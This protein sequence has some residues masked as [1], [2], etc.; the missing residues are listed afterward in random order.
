MTEPDATNGEVPGMAACGQS[1]DDAGPGSGSSIDNRQL[2]EFL[3][4]N[5]RTT[6]LFLALPV[7]AEQFLNFLV[8]FVDTLLSGR[9][10]MAATS[11]IGTAAYVNWLV[12]LIFSLVATGTTALVAR[13]W[14]AGQRDAAS[15]VASSSISLA[16]GMGIVAAALL[17]MTAPVFGAFLELEA[18][19]SVLLVRYLRLSCFGYGF[20]SVLLIG[21]A[22]LR[23]S[24][25]M[26]APMW[27]LGLVS[28]LNVVFSWTLVFGVGLLP[29]IGIDGIAIGTVAARFVGL[30]LMLWILVGGT[31]GLVGRPSW[32]ST[33]DFATISRV[34]RIG[35]PAATDS[36]LMWAGHFLFLR[37]VAGLGA[38]SQGKAILAAHI[39]GMQVEAIN[40]LPAWAW[41]TAAATM[42][43]Q[44]LG[45]GR[46]DRVR[47]AGH[48][49]MLQS[50]V[51]AVVVM[52]LFLC[53]A[54]F[55]YE[56][57]HKNQEVA[58]VGVPAIRLLAF[59]EVPLSI[60]IVY[61]VGIR[62]AGETF[63]PMI[64][65]GV[66]IFFVRL[67]IGYWLG[68]EM[69]LGLIGAWGGM[70]ADVV[71][72]ATAIALYFRFGKWDQ[73]GI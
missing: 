52:I 72:R 44:C 51:V 24:G 58:S 69:D 12:E 29:A 3:T 21:S 11:A 17:Y 8:G 37:V 38:G 60:S 53:G 71:V 57:M 35:I 66:G 30:V 48:E 49:A 33:M 22:A 47:P 56:L 43:G 23:G 50:C 16:L 28:V 36:L 42:I 26:R 59:F 34:L 70:G 55:I 62:G 65:N 14:G 5:P 68:V 2:T 45:A 41:G 13:H 7:L 31:A 61:T 20:S 67:P 10:S 6:I 63:W 18:E 64:I 1:A 4:G 40:Y 32:V 54:P 39:V 25:N 27:I 9:I 46:A 15:R 19:S 73:K